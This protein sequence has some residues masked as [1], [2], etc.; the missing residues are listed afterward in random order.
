MRGFKESAIVGKIPVGEA[1]IA[2]T[3]SP[4]GKLL[5][6]TSELAPK[7]WNWPAE[8]KPEGQDPAT[9]KIEYS[10]GAI[11]VVDVA[12]AEADPAH[13]VIAKVPAG[14]SP[15]RM[16]ISPNGDTVYITAR[17]SNA[18]LAFNAAKLVSDSNNALIGKV[19]VG[20]APVPI[21]V[22]DNGKKILA[23]NSN[24]FAAGEND[25]QH[26]T[27]IDAS[28]ISSG[29]AAVMGSLPAQGFPREFGYSADGRT[30]FLANYSSNS[31]EVIDVPRLQITPK[32]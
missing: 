28:K 3:F 8:C 24:R 19:P 7:E 20:S 26:V 25:K 4:D 2:L 23:G 5:Y 27:V 12:K 10:A 11:I 9:A 21:A 29:E 6:T 16:A 17:N 31:L 30:L 32:M 18:V 15:V 22:A 14:C 13:S 1:P